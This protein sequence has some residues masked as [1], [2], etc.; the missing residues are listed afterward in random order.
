[1]NN[2]GEKI[3]FNSF[4]RKLYDDNS[5]DA[6]MINLTYTIDE[7]NKLESIIRNRRNYIG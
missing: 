4:G 3:Y 2:E 1:M 5:T 7:E 6:I